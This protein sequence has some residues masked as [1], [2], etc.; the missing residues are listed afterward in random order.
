YGDKS[1]KNF[2]NPVAF[3]LSALGTFGN[4][5]A[6][7]VRGPSTWQFDAAVSRSFQLRESQ[8]MDFR[9][10]AFNVANSFRMENPTPSI[11]STFFGQVTAAK[12]PRIM[13]FSLKY[14]F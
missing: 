12:D 2:L 8:R 11:D 4:V 1:V 3:G 7:S 9:A 14:L 13:Q 10:E 5:G 6:N